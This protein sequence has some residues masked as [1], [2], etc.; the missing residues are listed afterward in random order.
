[1]AGNS[2]RR[3]PGRSV[4]VL[5]DPAAGAHQFVEGAEDRRE[6]GFGLHE[7]VDFSLLRRLGHRGDRHVGSV[8]MGNAPDSMDPSY[9]ERATGDPFRISQME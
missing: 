3:H 6:E 4:L 8:Q 1:L 9:D 7:R 5:A 2:P